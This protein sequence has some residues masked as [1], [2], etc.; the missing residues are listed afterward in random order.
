M[1][2]RALRMVEFEDAN[3]D[4]FDGDG[5]MKAIPLEEFETERFLLRTLYL[6]T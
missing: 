4:E 2:E 6:L 3:G 5:L 1:T